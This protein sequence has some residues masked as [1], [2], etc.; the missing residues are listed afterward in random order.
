MIDRSYLRRIA[1]LGTCVVVTTT[2]CAFDG[3]NSLPLPGVEGYG[4]G[5]STYHVEIANVA[6]LESNS[7]VMIG[8]VVVGSVGRMRVVGW[9][10]D[11]EVSVKSGAVVPAN[12]VATVGQTSLLGSMHL[13]LNPPLGQPPNGS[14]QPGTTI[15]L[16]ESSTYPSTEQTL[17]SLSAVANAGSLG[18]FGDVIHSLNE[19]MSGNQD[20]I[21][22]V[23][24]RFD[25]LVGTLD[26]QTNHIVDS[27][28]ALNR[29]MGTLAA[30]RDVITRALQRIPKAVE[31]LIRERPRITEA[32][33]KFGVFS[34]NVT[35]L[36]N[37]SQ[38]D[39]VSTLQDLQPTIKA[40]ADVGPDLDQALAFLP[41]FPFPQNTIDRGV[42]GDYLN[43]FAEFDFTIPRLRNSLLL[44]TRF[45]Q[46]GRPLVPAPGE[47]GYLNYTYD[48]LNTGVNPPAGGP[49]PTEAPGEPGP[50][51]GPPPAS[52]LPIPGSQDPGPES[53]P[54][55]VP[56][57]PPPAPADASPTPGGS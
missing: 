32:L 3:L 57:A 1:V 11:V 10:A 33:R 17:A 39:L 23:L 46:E 2:G 47:P 49:A 37:N 45:G 52:P 12:A 41:T 5:A 8:D 48:P 40:L 36:I 19:A 43:L 16:N 55:G 35:G 44:G 21:R 18:R 53:S 38:A 7:P 34:D 50:D 56:G 24:T 29:L 22:D 31:V 15:A 13:Q 51:A 42:R 30:N 4:A 26:G 27:I 28:N 14:L 25:D 9:H 20:K 6:T 54:G